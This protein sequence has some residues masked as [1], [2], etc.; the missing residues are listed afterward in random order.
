M[1][2]DPWFWLSLVS[3]MIGMEYWSRWVHRVLWHGPLW[4]GHASHH[5]PRTGFWERND[6]FAVWHALIAAPMVYAGL[7]WQLAPLA[8]VGFGMTL[9][10]AAYFTVHDGF[11]HG[12]LPVAFLG[13]FAWLRRV[14][15][16]HHAHHHREHAAPFGLFLGP[17]ELRALQRR[18]SERPA[19][20][21]TA[22][23]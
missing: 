8:G 16:A 13:R 2:V 19:S 4:S 15:N 17:Q 5:A 3:A 6:I 23:A 20:A 10:G 1:H 7:R 22:G 11:I 14:R 9:F 18:R 12:R 21:S